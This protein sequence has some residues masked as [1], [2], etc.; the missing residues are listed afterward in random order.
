MKIT[1]N[2]ISKIYA[3][4]A[5][6]DDCSFEIVLGS[7]VAIVGENGSGKSTILKLLSGLENVSEGNIFIPKGSEVGYLKQEFDT[8]DGVVY[9]YVIESFKELKL[10]ETRIEEVSQRLS[11]M[12]DFEKNMNL[13][14]RLQEEFELKDGYNIDNTIERIANGLDVEDLLFENYNTLSGGEKTRVE[15][16]RLLCSDVNILCLDEPTNHLDFKGIEWLETYCKGLNKTLVIVSHDR[17]FL[18]SVVDTYFDLEYGSVVKYNG[19]FEKF[20]EE[21]RQRFLSLLNDYNQQQKIIQKMKLAIRRYRQWGNESDNED[22]Y[23][24]AKTLE[25]RLEKME[26]LP[27]PEEVESKLNLEFIKTRRS[28]KDV[29]TVKDLSIGY[30]QPLKSGINIKI[31]YQ[32]RLVLLGENG[33]GK[34]TFIKTILNEVKPLSGTLQLGTQ[35]D[36]G[37]MSQTH[38]FKDPKERLLNY[39]I[40]SLNCSEFNARQALAQYGFYQDDVYKPLSILS[41]GEKVRVHLMSIMLKGVNFLILDEPTNHLDIESCEIL[42]RILNEYNGTLLIVSHDR[43]FLEKLTLQKLYF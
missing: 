43:Y 6:L 35:I 30:N 17:Q 40:K 7:K 24:K 21:K 11:T 34:T 42:E 3:E 32:D 36:L 4:E 10:L 28:G 15:L 14:G 5:I 20:R 19:T 33:S 41:G 25:K 18:S 31:N 9:D 27:K 39:V 1:F 13:L 38:T 16:V 26:K 29:L 37:Y 12:I 2:N 22:F 23:K 8:F